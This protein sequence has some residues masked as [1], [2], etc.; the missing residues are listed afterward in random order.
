[1]ASTTN[2][3]D[4]QTVVTNVS[5]STRYFGFLPYHSKQLANNAS[6]T[7]EGDLDD[8][9]N[10]VKRRRTAYNAAIAAGLIEIRRN[11]RQIQYFQVVSANQITNGD[12][13][14][15][16]TSTDTLYRAQEQA[17]GGSATLTR[18]NFA[19]VFVGRALATHT[20]GSGIVTNFPVDI[21]PLSLYAYACTSEAHELDELLT[22]TVSGNLIASS[23]TL[24]KTATATEAIASVARRDAS[25]ATTV[26]ARFSSY[27][28]KANSAAQV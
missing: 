7:W 15:Y 13:V 17:D 4:V 18:Q 25:A 8:W 3:S 20:A 9:L 24:V 10:K 5:G 22:P 23:V 16:L 28:M 2:L 27:L 14:G 21:S 11:F 26:L 6:F 19:N 1:M 12:L